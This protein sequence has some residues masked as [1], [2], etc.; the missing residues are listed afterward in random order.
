MKEV[1]EKLPKILLT[2]I[3][4]YLHHGEEVIAF[5]KKVW[6]PRFDFSWV[7]LTNERVIIAT[8]KIFEV[9]FTDYIIRNIDMDVSL[10]FPFDTLT[11]EAF[12][13][14]YTGQFYWYNREK[15]LGFIEKI[16]AKIEE[17]ERRLGEKGKLTKGKEEE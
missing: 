9:N 17:Q 10:G 12:R 13:K 16:K 5:L 1:R 4:P 7:V 6:V 8:R 14:K 15:T 11:F 3:V 2:N